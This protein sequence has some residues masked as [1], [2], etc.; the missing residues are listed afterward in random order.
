[1]VVLYALHIIVCSI[2]LVFICLCSVRYILLWH[3]STLCKMID[4]RICGTVVEF[5]EFGGGM[6]MLYELHMYVYSK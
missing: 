6:V 5:Y 2:G 1:M 4:S 3:L